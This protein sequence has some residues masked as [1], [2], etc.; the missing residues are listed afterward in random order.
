MVVLDNLGFLLSFFFR[1]PSG[2]NAIRVGIKRLGGSA[3]DV[4]PYSANTDTGLFN[5][6]GIVRR[7]QVGKGTTPA[8]RQ[9]NNIENA[10]PDSPESGQV[11]SL[12]GGYN[13]G[14]GKISQSTLISNLGGAGS[15]T[16]VIKVF[17]IVDV[18]TQNGVDCAIFR[19]VISPVG[20]IVG[21][22]LNITHEVL[23]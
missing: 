14:L 2:S 5:D 15:V 18:F 4:R 3:L 6:E 20:F 23:I 9:D 19:D 1:A 13:S 10:F 17:K 11:S 21:E 16:E 22:S 7:A 8:T 12:N